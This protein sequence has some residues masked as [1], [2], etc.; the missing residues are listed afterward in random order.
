MFTMA[1]RLMRTKWS[2][3]WSNR[4]DVIPFAICDF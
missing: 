2:D 3:A 4:A 1:E